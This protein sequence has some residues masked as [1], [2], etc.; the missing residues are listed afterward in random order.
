MENQIPIKASGQL[1]ARDI[2]N[3]SL[4]TI[5]RRFRWFLIVIGLVALFLIA[6]IAEN[7][8]NLEWTLPNVLTPLF[9]LVFIPYA[10][11]VAPYFSARK[12]IQTSPNL[13]GVITYE[14]SSGGV[15]ISAPNS[16]AHLNWAA[17]IEA[18]ET[19]DQFFLYPQTAMAHVIPKRFLNADDVPMLRALLRT[20]VAKT[21][22]K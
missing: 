12:R 21:K 4:D 7:A 15:E 13:S 19:S 3:F 2:Y 18:R 11:F 10:F 16:Q 9:I 1:T 20:H 17:L 6:N 5:F 22:L 8:R 14:F